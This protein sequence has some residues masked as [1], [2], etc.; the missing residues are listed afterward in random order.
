LFFFFFSFVVEVTNTSCN[1]R[2]CEVPGS[3]L[4]E[5]VQHCSTNTYDRRHYIVRCPACASVRHDTNTCDYS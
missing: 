5:G 3:N 4:I 2:I 1:S